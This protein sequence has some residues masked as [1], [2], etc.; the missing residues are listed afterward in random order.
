MD[1]GMP[2]WIQ[3]TVLFTLTGLFTLLLRNRNI[4]YICLKPSSTNTPF[5]KSFN[6]HLHSSEQYL[7]TYSDFN[8]KIMKIIER[9]QCIWQEGCATKCQ[10]IIFPVIIV[11]T[12]GRLWYRL[13]P[14]LCVIKAKVNLFTDADVLVEYWLPACIRGSVFVCV[15]IHACIHAYSVFLDFMDT[16][17]THSIFADLHKKHAKIIVLSS[18]A[19][20]MQQKPGLLRL[21]ASASIRTSCSRLY[22]AGNTKRMLRLG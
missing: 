13:L 22:L 21:C 14:W 3:H 18:V 19:M 17:S 7:I 2:R 15:C 4:I 20:V 9:S 16:E 8:R 11:W 5:F 10:L 12:V 1:A 6:Q